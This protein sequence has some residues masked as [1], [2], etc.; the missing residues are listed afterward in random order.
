MQWILLHLIYKLIKLTRFTLEEFVEYK[1]TSI[2]NQ[3]TSY[4]L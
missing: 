1:S 2:V 3:V 4:L